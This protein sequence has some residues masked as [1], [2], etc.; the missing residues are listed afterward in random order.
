MDEDKTTQQKT[1]SQMMMRVGV[2]FF[3]GIFVGLILGYGL[4]HFLHTQPWGMVL[5]I[6]LGAA[7]GFRNIL[8]IQSSAKLTIK[9]I[10]HNNIEHENE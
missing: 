3:S 9:T 6:L 5:M 4:D 2:E 1:M 8:K 7:A 10:P